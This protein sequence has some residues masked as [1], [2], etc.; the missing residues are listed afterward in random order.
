MPTDR[1]LNDFIQ[2]W[3]IQQDLYFW[4]TC[5][6]SSLGFLHSLNL[7]NLWH[8]ASFSW[9]WCS[10]NFRVSK[11]PGVLVKTQ[12]ARSGRVSD[13]AGL[14]WVVSECAFLINTQVMPLLLVPGP[15][16]LAWAGWVHPGFTILWQVLFVP[17]QLL[18]PRQ[19]PLLC[20]PSYLSCTFVSLKKQ[21][22][23]IYLQLLLVISDYHLPPLPL[24]SDSHWTTQVDCSWWGGGVDS[25][26]QNS[27][28]FLCI[29]Y[30]QHHA[31]HMV[32]VHMYLLNE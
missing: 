23:L 3:D 27:R 5:L 25:W 26:A 4:L 1:E 14:C 20:V 32:N 31:W 11:S 21:I 16:P 29:E 8:D 9:K 6:D 18:L 17:S 10:S 15:Q 24:W 2:K 30:L 7:L 19:A 13:S 12:L 28:W 22:N